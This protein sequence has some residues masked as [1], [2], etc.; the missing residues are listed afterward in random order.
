VAAAKMGI[1]FRVT[2]NAYGDNEKLISR[3]FKEAGRRDEIFLA[4]KF[5]RTIVDGVINVTG[6]PASTAYRLT[7]LICTASIG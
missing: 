3:Y 4:T 1:N 5:G 7:T 6:K 2:S